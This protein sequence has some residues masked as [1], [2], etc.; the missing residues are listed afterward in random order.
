MPNVTITMNLR[1]PTGLLNAS[2][3]G[4]RAGLYLIDLLQEAISGKNQCDGIVYSVTDNA[5]LGTGAFAQPAIAGVVMATASGAVGA[6]IG[7]VLVT[8]AHTG[9]DVTSSTALAAAI[10][11][12]GTVN[13]KVTATNVSMR[14]TLTAVTA[15]QFIDFAGVR[16]TAV[17]GAAAR[18]GEFSIAGTDVAD[19]L[20][21]CLAINRHP[22][23][24]LRYAAVSN[25]NTVFVFPTTNRAIGP[26]QDKWAQITNPGGFTTFVLNVAVPAVGPVTAVLATVPGDIGNEVRL[27]ASGL[28]T[29][30]ATGGA[31]GFLGHGD[32]GAQ[33]IFNKP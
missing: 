28:G 16:F 9:N 14:T 4:T 27:A 17:A 31:V 21:L 7:G 20:E 15:G 13:R 25:A 10:R 12:L 18:H 22:S 2:S 1:R 33:S 8:V 24:T 11:A 30:A 26:T 5:L 19:A 23:T 3:L 6:T 32:G 29:T